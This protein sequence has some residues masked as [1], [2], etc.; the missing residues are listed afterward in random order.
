MK[1]QKTL[2][3][4]DYIR[5]IEDFPSKGISFKDITTLI[6]D[7]AAFAETVD[8]LAALLDPEVEIIAGPEARGFIFGT[9]LAYKIGCGFV[10]I[11][12]PGKLPD[13]VHRYEYSLEYGTD[14][15]EVHADAFEGGAKVAI[16]DDLLATGGTLEAC[17]KLIELSG[18]NV[19]NILAVIE[20]EDLGGRQKLSAYNTK[21]IVQYDF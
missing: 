10:P 21:T 16:V 2:D 18:G 8:Q 20:L 1:E 15:L 4:K 12:K 11:R 9:A 13:K 5:I 7:K 3:L 17:A 19:V 6:K 14:S